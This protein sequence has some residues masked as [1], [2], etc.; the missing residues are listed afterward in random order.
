MSLPATLPQAILDTILSRLAL[1]FLSGAGDNMAVARDAVRQL[2]PGNRPRAQSR[3]RNHQPPNARAGR[4]QLRRQ[5]R[6][7]ANKILRLRGSAVSLSREQHKAHRKL[8]QIQ[9]V[10]RAG[11]QPQVA[12]PLPTDPKIEKAIAVVQAERPA[13]PAQA[14]PKFPSL[15]TFHK[16]EA[17]RLITENLRKKQADYASQIAAAAQPTTSSASA[18]SR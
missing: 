16:Q 1:L 10:R 5:P 17:A 14:S 6:Y 4:A 2:Q 15:H 18:I 8:D 3:G 11:L 7:G 13:A 12:E 9:K